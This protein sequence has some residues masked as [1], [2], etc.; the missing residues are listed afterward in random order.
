MARWTP[1]I[2]PHDDDQSVYLVVEEAAT[3]EHFAKPM[4]SRLI[5]KP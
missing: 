3:A 5:W 1:S 2:V 4:S